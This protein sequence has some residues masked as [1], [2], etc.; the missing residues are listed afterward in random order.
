MICNIQATSCAS[1]V[2]PFNPQNRLIST[3]DVLR[4]LEKYDI[5][6][7]S[8]NIDVYRCAM[9]HKSY[10]T[11]KNENFLEGNTMCPDGCI[12][13][14]EESNERLEFLG[15]S[16]L[17]IIVAHYL[18]ERYPDEN[19]G[20]LTRMRTKIVNGKMLAYLCK[21]VELH[22]F[23]LLSKQIEE[24]DGRS[25]SNI[26]EDA[27]EAFLA[28][29][30]LDHGFELAREWVVSVLENTLD[31]SELVRQNNNYKDTFLKFFQQQF[32]YMPK[33]LEL[34][35]TTQNN[36]KVYKMCIKNNNNI[37]ISVGLGSNKKE[38]ENSAAKIA[39]EQFKVC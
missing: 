18:Y 15:D 17:S 31:F 29:V 3:D 4:I 8:I 21:C 33:F 28:A 38:A 7:E 23:I 25:N 14:Q 26:L 22:R 39:L 16:V 30:Y 2:V 9:V 27:F 37:I 10:C 36:Q 12:P 5:K 20:F 19:E 32:G 35:V 13:L 1:P 6:I 34:D 11:R 24:N